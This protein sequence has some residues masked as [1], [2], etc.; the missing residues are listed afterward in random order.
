M[1]NKEKGGRERTGR[2]LPCVVRAR[3][4]PGSAQGGLGCGAVGPPHAACAARTESSDAVA[5]IS[6]LSRTS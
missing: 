4:T 3:P 6:W 1:E 2:P 5:V